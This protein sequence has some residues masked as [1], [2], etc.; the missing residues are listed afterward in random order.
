MDSFRWQGNASTLIIIPVIQ[1]LPAESRTDERITGYFK[2]KLYWPLS[3]V[4]AQCFLKWS[5]E[6]PINLFQFLAFL[7]KIVP[8][9]MGVV[10]RTYSEILGQSV[11]LT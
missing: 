1:K 6:L 11:G 7:L 5:T 10:E 8:I 9:F 3:A 2:P 4:H